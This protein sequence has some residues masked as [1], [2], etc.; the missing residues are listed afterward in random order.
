[1]DVKPNNDWQEVNLQL[2][3]DELAVNRQ[4]RLEAPAA[5]DWEVL[6]VKYGCKDH[7]EV[8]LL[9]LQCPVNRV[10]VKQRDS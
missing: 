2:A 7:I 6:W 8:T 3:R 9:R 5:R 10:G 4:F 1:M